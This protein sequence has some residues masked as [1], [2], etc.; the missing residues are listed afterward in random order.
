MSSSENGLNDTL[1]FDAMR[2]IYAELDSIDFIYILRMLKSSFVL[3]FQSLVLDFVD[4]MSHFLM[5]FCRDRIQPSRLKS[6][7]L[8]E[9]SLTYSVTVRSADLAPSSFLWREFRLSR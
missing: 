5:I 7:A 8:S 6:L 4:K 2:V 9:H 1:C 3:K